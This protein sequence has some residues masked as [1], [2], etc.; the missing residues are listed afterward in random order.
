MKR[1]E[2][3]VGSQFARPRGLLGQLSVR[4]MRRSNAP[5]NVWMVD[6]LGVTPHDRVLEVGFGPGVA[7]ADLLARA[8]DGFVV[9]VDASELM[10]R[11]ARSRHADAIAMGRLEIR[12]GDAGSLPDDD[13]AFDKVCGTHV[14]YFWA[15]AV[16]T[17]RELRRVLRP[18]GTLALAYQERDRMPPRAA[19]G[20]TRAGARLVGPGEVEEVVRAAGFEDIRVETKVAP[21]GPAGFCLVALK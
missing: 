3:T 19:A 14:I 6:L 5:L 11:Q 16:A 21:Q 20:L 4:V 18:G 10:V 2:G 9:G 1:L 8:S 13:A 7:L 17:V 12:Q 15:D